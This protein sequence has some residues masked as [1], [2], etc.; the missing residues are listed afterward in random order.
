MYHM[1]KVKIMSKKTF[2]SLLFLVLINI[3]ILSA[4]ISAFEENFFASAQ[5][6]T[7]NLCQC[8]NADNTITVRNTNEFNEQVTITI[9]DSTSETSSRKDLVGLPSTYMVSQ[10]GSAAKWSSVY[11]KYF[12]L[13]AGQTEKVENII[14]APCSAKGSYD[15]HTVIK[16]ELGLEKVITQK[17]IIT[18]C[19]NILITPV[20]TKAQGCP[21]TPLTFELNVKNT[22]SFVE[23]YHIGVSENV[24]RFVTITANPIILE[25]GKEEKVLIF[26]N[27]PCGMHGEHGIE[28]TVLAEKNKVIKRVGLQAIINPCYDFEITTGNPIH[29]YENFTRYEFIPYDGVYSFCEKEQNVRIPIKITNNADLPNEYTLSIEGEEWASLEHSSVHNLSKNEFA[30]VYLSINPYAYTK[31]LY[32]FSLHITTGI[33]NFEKV[34]N[35]PLLLE[36]CY[37]PLISPEVKKISVNYST[38]STPLTIKNI[39]NKKGAYQVSINLDWGEITPPLFNLDKND[40]LV[41]NLITYPNNETIEGTY[42]SVITVKSIDNGVEYKKNLK[43]IL[44]E[45]ERLGGLFGGLSSYFMYLIVGLVLMLIFIAVMF[46]ITKNGGDEEEKEKDSQKTMKHIA[47]KEERSAIKEG[48]PRWIKLSLIAAIVIFAVLI[49]I[50]YISSVLTPSEI[51]PQ[52]TEGTVNGT[53]QAQD[54]DIHKNKYGISYHEPVNDTDK[55]ETLGLISEPEVNESKINETAPVETAEEYGLKKVF[56]TQILGWI[57]LYIWYIISGICIALLLIIILAYT[58]KNGSEEESEV[59]AKKVIPKKEKI[60]V[61]KEGKNL[62]WLIAMVIFFSVII[63]V[64]S[65]YYGYTW[66]T[67]KIVAEP[68]VEL[69]ELNETEGIN[70]TITVL[71]ESVDELTI[72]ISEEE[73]AMKWP[74]NTKSEINLSKIFNDPDGDTLIFS[75]NDPE[76]LS[77]DIDETGVASLTPDKDYYGPIDIQFTADDNKG[78]VISTDVRIC[79]YDEDISSATKLWNLINNYKKYSIIG[80]G[81]IIIIIFLI[82]YNKPI[83]RFLEEDNAPSQKKQKKQKKK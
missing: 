46:I 80:L 67:S 38:L 4:T 15:L 24:R 50:Y 28:V 64:L 31:G 54:T 34:Y 23:K 66:Y 3:L 2:I 61:K 69:P 71:N 40:S 48:L 18:E 35:I 59:T 75:S 27:T 62:G 72:N 1:Q 42:N 29:S 63:V 81:I 45:K 49:G 36:W 60:I 30:Y 25:P 11:P 5:Y 33:G 7:I 20:R 21:C 16:T 79:I 13:E 73:C 19:N 78:S 9:D 65:G 32:N 74:K 6:N 53:T 17:V 12:S 56:W 41:V 83:I 39:G 10:D 43:I 55:N 14:T 37:T 52:T 22:G 82:V 68:F 70:D 51:T 57:Y 8:S 44:S 77:V 47:E 26:L 58:S 76:H